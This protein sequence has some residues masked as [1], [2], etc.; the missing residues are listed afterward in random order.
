MNPFSYK[1]FGWFLG[2]RQWLLLA[3]LLGFGAQTAVAQGPLF[4]W[5]VT[6]NAAEVYLLGSIHLAKP[7]MYPLDARIEE[8]FRASDDVVVEV[9]VS[10]GD[11]TQ[12]RALALQLGM[13]S[14]GFTVKDHLSPEGF[15]RFQRF[16]EERSLPLPAF[17]GFRPWM[18]AAMLQILEMQRVGF[19]TEIGIE[20]H[21][22][23]LAEQQGKVVHELETAEF[24][25][26]MLAEMSDELQELFLISTIDE[27]ASFAE[28]ID[29]MIVA[30]KIGDSTELANMLLKDYAEKPEMRPLYQRILIDRN[31]GMAQKIVDMLEGGGKWFVIVG[32]AHLVG[33]EGLV[34]ILQQDAHGFQV[35]QVGAADGE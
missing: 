31:V 9:D 17:Q 20:R 14:D 28:R 22:L 11:M 1:K 13:Y 6:S 35:M 25:L 29:R 33:E 15:V 30:W 32:A 19:D 24:Q 8:A 27:Y 16:L 3:F 2:R 10:G 23:R 34:E 5:K 21:F 4:L 26:R 18:L 12:Q 7:D